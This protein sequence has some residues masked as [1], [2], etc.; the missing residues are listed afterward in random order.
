MY[1]IHREWYYPEVV[2]CKEDPKAASAPAGLHF[3]AWTGYKKEQAT[4]SF[5]QKGA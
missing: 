3:G 4:K 1:A 5:E 2:A